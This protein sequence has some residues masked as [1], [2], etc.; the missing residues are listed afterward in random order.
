[1]YRL[2]LDDHI[3]GS[4]HLL[5]CGFSHLQES[6]ITRCLKLTRTQA[7]SDHKLA[8]PFHSYHKND[9]PK[10]RQCLSH[11]HYLPYHLH[12]YRFLS[13]LDQR[14]GESTLRYLWFGCEEGFVSPAESFLNQPSQ[15][16]Q[17]ALFGLFENS[18]LILLGQKV[19]SLGT[20]FLLVQEN[21]E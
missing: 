4:R 10:Q 9:N 2:P 6:Y 18:A 13:S 3:E 11:R 17:R 8:I 20:I 19:L 15:Q 21:V 16:L 12:R 7:K 14:D 5:K 1:M